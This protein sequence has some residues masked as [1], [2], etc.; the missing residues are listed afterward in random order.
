MCVF[1]CVCV[2]QVKV[3]RIKNRLDPGHDATWTAGYRSPETRARA[4]TR[5]HPRTHAPTHTQARK[6]H[7]RM[8]ARARIRRNARTHTPTHT[9]AQ[10]RTHARTQTCALAETLPAARACRAR[11]SGLLRRPECDRAPRTAVQAGRMRRLCRE[12]R[13]TRRLAHA[14]TIPH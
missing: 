12:L 14:H 3:V 7:V 9:H 10:A 13:L 5:T 4:S 1:A 2:C 6:Q 8:H 11:S